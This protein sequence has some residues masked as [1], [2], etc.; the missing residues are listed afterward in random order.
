MGRASPRRKS[1]SNASTDA[2]V[3]PEPP[4]AAPS[5]GCL[6][7]GPGSQ[8]RS[9]G[10]LSLMA[11][12][13]FIV[14][15]HVRHGNLPS[16]VFILICSVEAIVSDSFLD[17]TG[18]WALAALRTLRV[19]AGALSLASL[20]PGSVSADSWSTIFSW[21]AHAICL[22]LPLAALLVLLWPRP[23]HANSTLGCTVVGEDGFLLLLQQRRPAKSSAVVVFLH[24]FA[25]SSLVW[26]ATAEAVSTRYGLDCVLV[27]YHRIDPVQLAHRLSL[28][29]VARVL[30]GTLERHGLSDR[31]RILVGDSMGGAMAMYYVDRFVRHACRLI[32][33]CP[34][35]IPNGMLDPLALSVTLLRWSGV[36]GLVADVLRLFSI[37]L[38][39]ASI[40]S[41]SDGARTAYSIALALEF[42][43]T[44]PT[45]DLQHGAVRRLR[46]RLQHCKRLH[47]KRLCADG[48]GLV[49]MRLLWGET[50][51]LHWASCASLFTE[52]VEGC[53]GTASLEMLR[54]GHTNCRP[55]AIDSLALWAR[56][57]LWA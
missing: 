8:D 57:E 30:H 12:A 46:Q 29:A 13:A 39:H 41:L 14:A 55:S 15:W 36:P 21:T 23:P 10:S 54:G 11:S 19:V 7:Q 48:S 37:P 38:V 20:Y 47:C 31:P 45:Y 28:H 9:L 25:Q 52:P 40:P 4:A 50:D 16:V 32:L 56:P 26:T 53:C 35:G 42:V 27:D 17:D 24:G 43:L 22:V 5:I 44:T 49:D 2:P 1:G 18:I 33:V 51:R 6:I 3:A 34:A